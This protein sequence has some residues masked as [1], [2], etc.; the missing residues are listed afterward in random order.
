[1][2][3]RYL[4]PGQ[5]RFMSDNGF[6]VLM[7]SA[8]GKELEEVK[9]K[10]QCRHIVVPMTRKITPF[11]D[12][13]CLFKLISIFRKEKPAIVH[14]HTPK[15]G[16]LGMLAARICGIK[17]RIHTVA[18]LP[19]MVEKGMKYRLL[20]FIER[21]T[22][23]SATQV[24]PNSNSLLQFIKEKKLVDA[25]KLHMIAKGSTNGI[26]I[27]RF[28]KDVLDE[29]ILSEI[30]AQTGHSSQNK[31]L[32][33]IG[34]LVV[35]KGIVE[36]VNVFK[37]LQRSDAALRLLLVGG[38]E[39]TL[40]PLP[41]ATM[42]EIETNKDIIHINWSDK[43]EYFMQLADLF[44]FPSHREGFPNVLLQAGAMGLPVVCSR[45]TGNVDIVS[46]N[47]TGSI[48]EPA[49]EQQM[50]E[51]LQYAISHPQQAQAMADKLQ[52]IVREDYRQENIWQNILEAYKS[53]VN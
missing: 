35:D 37:Q 31:Y 47:E 2:A 22:Y 8:A 5:M 21:I 23:A 24:W 49:N 43:V 32:L 51:L 45:I 20:K 10:E 40:D 34:R 44:V 15:A 13:R 12:L 14:T 19:M 3:L 18:G 33:C 25:A 30:K 16:L 9:E 27:N 4:L 29:N 28:N 26:D 36:L 17:T 52:K 50:L 53:V 41:S 7:I 42:K 6:D 1:M 39:P 11:Q 38:Y 48:F 46:N